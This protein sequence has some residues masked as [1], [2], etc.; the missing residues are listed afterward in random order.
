VS[1]HGHKRTSVDEDHAET[2]C[3]CGS[4]SGGKPSDREAMQLLRRHFANAV[5][6]DPPASFGVDFEEVRFYEDMGT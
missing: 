5:R 1:G 3:H 6:D 4:R 2:F